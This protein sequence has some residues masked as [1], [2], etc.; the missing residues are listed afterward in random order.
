MADNTDKAWPPP[1]QVPQ[2]LGETA[3]KVLL[4][5][6]GEKEQ[7][8]RNRGPVV[9]WACRRWLSK[10]RYEEMLASGELLWCA[11]AVCSAFDEAGSQAIH[12]VASLSCATLW[13]NCQRRGY[14]FG[15]L[16]PQLQMVPG[17][18]VFTDADKDGRP[19]H[20]AIVERAEGDR[21]HVV[22][23]NSGP[24]PGP[25]QRRQADRVARSTCVLDERIF[26]F[27]RLVR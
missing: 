18:I 24:D 13:G 8:G 20:V 9:E 11:G 4:S 10:A 16:D 26:G 15:L 19:G 1:P 14:T 23:G 21:L 22:S 3:L 5:H 7:G 12:E 25:G 27:A 6:L 2:W 17:D